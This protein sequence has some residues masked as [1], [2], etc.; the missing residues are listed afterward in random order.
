MCPQYMCLEHMW[1]TTGF[2]ALRYDA[3]VGHREVTHD[4]ADML[5]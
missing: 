4:A 3:L 1:T 5:Y 2:E